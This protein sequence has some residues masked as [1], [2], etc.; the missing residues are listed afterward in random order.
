MVS[1]QTIWHIG[2]LNNVIGYA[3][4]HMVQNCA[5]ATVPDR[6]P[7]DRCKYF[8]SNFFCNKSLLN[9]WR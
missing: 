8:N 9:V 4:E 5:S 2:G 6:P 1:G 7:R 3:R